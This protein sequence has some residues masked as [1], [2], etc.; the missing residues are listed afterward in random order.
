MNRKVKGIG[1]LSG[2]LDSLL[3]VKVLQEQGIELLGI[4]FVTPFFGPEAGMEAG[5]KAGIRMLA[6]DISERHLEMLKSPKYGYGS[7]MNPCIDCHGLM[8]KEAGRLMESEG[9]DFLFTGEVL[10]QRPMSQRRDSLR[11]VE[12]LSGCS[13]RILRP[14]SAKLLDPTLVE[15]EGLV[16]RNRL[17]DIQ[18][19][20]RK[21]QTELANHFEIVEYPQPGGGCMLTKEGFANRLR[22]LLRCHPGSTVRDVEIIKWG[23]AF[24]LPGDNLCMVGRQQADNSKLEKLAREEDVYLRSVNRPGP[25]CIILASSDP[26][27][28]LQIAAGLVASYSDGPDNTPIVVQ[29]KHRCDAGMITVKSEARESFKEML[30]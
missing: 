18:G 15:Q 21:R 22:E 27:A 16:D 6:I 9:A 28:P 24:L 5:A 10:G 2:G 17:L 8:L 7:Q 11:S 12:K 1:L 14:L 4:T 13:G 29:W 3:A 19:R 30:I 20:S 26:L 25:T 23:R